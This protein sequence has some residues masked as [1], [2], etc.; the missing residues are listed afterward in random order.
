MV[1]CRLAN[2][3]HTH[4]FQVCNFVCFCVCLC[5]GWSGFRDILHLRYLT[6]IP[7]AG[8]VRSSHFTQQRAMAALRGCCMYWGTESPSEYACFC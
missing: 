1:N 2:Y 4:T 3:Q 8:L 5:K 6:G 7:S